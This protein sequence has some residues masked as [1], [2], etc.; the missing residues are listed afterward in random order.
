MTDPSALK[1]TPAV[2]GN[3][4]LV[5]LQPT[6]R[7]ILTDSQSLHLLDIATQLAEW[8]NYVYLY[9]PSTVGAGAVD[10]PELHPSIY[11][12]FA[13]SFVGQDLKIGRYNLDSV[14]LARHFG[15]DSGR[16]QIDAVVSSTFAPAT[17]LSRA[18]APDDESPGPVVIQFEP[19]TEI[20]P[21]PMSVRA[22]FF[23]EN[24]MHAKT[25]VLAP[26][27]R[28]RVIDRAAEGGI[29]PSQLE[30]VVENVKVAPLKMDLEVLA[31]FRSLYPKGKTTRL[32]F[33]GRA[34][35]TKQPQRIIDAYDSLY[36]QAED[37]EIH[38]M[39]QNEDWG[40]FLDLKG[41]EHI[42][43]AVGQ[44][45]DDFK[46]EAARSHVFMCWSLDES[47]HVSMR[48]AALLG[49]VVLCVDNK[50]MRDLFDGHLPEEFWFKDDHTA[51]VAL[52]KKVV[53]DLPGH[54]ERL[55]PF[56]EWC[57]STNEQTS[58][59]RTAMLHATWHQQMQW[60]RFGLNTMYRFNPSTWSALHEALDAVTSR[61]DVKVA[62]RF[63]LQTFLTQLSH[64]FAMGMLRAPLPWHMRNILRNY[65]GLVDTGD[66]RVPNF[67]VP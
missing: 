32:L 25:I 18:L 24:A 21:D 55:K 65:V 38:A 48:E 56:R 1:F 20:L 46:R 2:K 54:N 42:T 11:P 45:P 64:M 7:N 35:P 22:Q 30:R 47:F 53:A 40:T 31:N 41:R 44:G 27:E 34:N 15:Q 13:D 63:T 39:T 3:R 36:Q 58:V 26:H 17:Q 4:F 52:L 43:S 19:G 28:K 62:G 49:N 29:S 14:C 67:L 12:V 61:P 59:A 23:T 33:A 60:D 66:T 16:Y 57:L 9:C 50:R 10:L 8:G 6:R 37:V 51:A 5:V